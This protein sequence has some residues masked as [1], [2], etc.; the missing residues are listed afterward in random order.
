[1]S[2]IVI[3]AYQ[4]DP[5]DLQFDFFAEFYPNPNNRSL[6][7]QAGIQIAS[8]F[9]SL[10]IGMAFGVIVGLILYPLYNFESQ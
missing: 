9:I 7:G 1:M 10:G 3:A 4:S 8:T 2:G 6:S 5:V